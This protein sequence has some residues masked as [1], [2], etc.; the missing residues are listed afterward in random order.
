MLKPRSVVHRWNTSPSHTPSGLSRPTHKK[1]KTNPNKEKKMEPNEKKSSN[2]AKPRRETPGWLKAFRRW[3][4]VI[5]TA[6]VLGGALLYVGLYVP[7]KAELNTSTSALAT[8]TTELEAANSKTT[9]LTTQISDLTTNIQT[10]EG[11]LASANL[12]MSIIKAMA[13][14]RTARLV[15]MANNVAGA[16]L[17]MNAVAEA[18]GQLKGLVTD[19]GQSESVTSMLATATQAQTTLQ[20][21]LPGV[22]TILEEMDRNLGSLYTDVTSNP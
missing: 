14:V 5:L 19:A 17:A 3:V 7:Q 9:D 11:D 16:P 18:L 20:T 8:A 21:D 2:Q 6:F 15:V 22:A 13:E 1:G 4:L 12:E 10:L